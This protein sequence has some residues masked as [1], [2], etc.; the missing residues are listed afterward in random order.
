ML[1]G[2]ALLRSA[3]RYAPQVEAFLG[4]LVRIPSV[5]GSHPEQAVAQR[6]LEEAQRLGLTAALP[7][8][9]P[10]R[11]NFLAVWGRGKAGFALIAHMDTVAAGDP[12]A[13][14]CPPFAG[15]VRGGRLLGRG[16]ADNK[17]GL[18]CGLYTLVLL[19]DE[20]I[21]DPDAARV[22]MAGVADEESG[23]CSPLGVRYLLDEG[24]IPA[25]AAIYTYTSDI[26]C[27]GHRG[28]LRFRVLARGRAVHSGS[29]AWSRGEEGLNASTG[30]AEVLLRLEKLLPPDSHPAFPGMR[31]TLTPGTLLHGG[32]F[33]SMVPA[34]AEALVDVRLLP[35]MSAEAVLAAV[36]GVLREVAAARPGLGLSVE[37]K[38]RL[39]AALVPAD[40][41]LVRAAQ[42]YTRLLTG[43]TWP[44]EGAGPANEGYMLIEQGIPTLCGFGP[45][46]GGAHAADE[47]VDLASLPVTMAMYA[48]IIHAVLNSDTEEN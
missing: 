12:Q 30:L 27:I 17:A 28:L 16:A 48:G 40:H 14:S 8:R 6:A 24:L 42:D 29:P 26:I 31:T 32:E 11:P 38:N 19:R 18:A 35:G 7:A 41:R 5:N 47:W 13:W 10:Q 3:R 2:E 36:E 37:V 46:G 43:R 21:L 33:E 1:S 20:G 23:A 4:D 45:T 44:V 9:D 22:W 15:E 39:P 25:Q 34:A